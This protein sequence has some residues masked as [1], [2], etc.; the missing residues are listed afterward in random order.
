MSRSEKLATL[1]ARCPQILPSLLQ[2]DFGDLRSEIARLDRAGVQGLHLDVM[3]GLFVP[4]LSYGL[5]IVE[6]L[7]GLTDLPLDTHLMIDRPE[8]Y[9]RQF[10]DAGADIITIHVEATDQPASVLRSIRELGAAAGLA[11][12][13]STP[14]ERIEPLLPDCD[15]VLVMSVDAGFGG[16]K[17]NPEALGK[18]ARLKAMDDY[19]FALEVDGGVNNDTIKSCVG[20]G[21]ELLVV[22]SAIFGKDDYQAAVQGLLAAI[23]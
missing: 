14:V 8:R 5:P 15:L 2:C 3:D 9:A 20:A 4:N 21:A 13:P 19:D 23:S 7:R 16:Q 18:L 6:A 10:F 17:L 1:R 11:F 12:N 22:G